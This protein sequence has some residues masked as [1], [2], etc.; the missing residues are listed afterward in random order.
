ML[1]VSLPF[2]VL[3]TLGG[4]ANTPQADQRKMQATLRVSPGPRYAVHELTLATG[5]V[6]REYVSP[7]GQVFAVAWKGPF[8]PDLRQLMGDY[9]DRYVQATPV[10]RG[11]HSAARVALPGL[12]VHSTG[13]TRAFSG[14]AFVP[15]LLP[16]GVAESELR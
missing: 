4:D 13:R 1:L 2:K 6:V 8:K 10:F 11:G 5:T 12:V 16:A 9:F 14:H 7:Q 15:Q 3:A